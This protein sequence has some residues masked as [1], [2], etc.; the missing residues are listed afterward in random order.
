MESELF[1]ITTGFIK[2]YNKFVVKLPEF[3]VALVVVLI[4]IALA[5]AVRKV[6]RTAMAR[7][8]TEGHVDILIAQIAYVG[9]LSVG[10]II[11]LSILGVELAALFTG[12]GVAGFAIGFA[13]KD[14]LGNF[15]SGIILLIQRPFTIGDAVMIADVEGTV[16]NIRIR[17]TEITTYDGRIVFIPNNTLSTSNIINLTALPERRVDVDVGISYGSDINEAIGVCL[18]AVGTLKGVAKDPA[19]EVLVIGFAD[20]AVM[21]QVRV[22]VAWRDE[23]YPRLKSE[24]YRLVKEAL[25]NAGIEI[26]FPIRTLYFNQAQALEPGLEGITSNRS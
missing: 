1:D 14:I 19:P 13:M 3:L 20:S 21:L 8:S 9:S 4:S 5:R 24:A 22:W 18:G 26:P 16:T 11:S 25:D 7:T 23:G 15:I 6:V 10:V 12:L 17:D 2:L